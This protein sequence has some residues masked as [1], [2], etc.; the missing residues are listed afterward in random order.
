M[1]SSSMLLAA[2]L[3]TGCLLGAAGCDSSEPGP[4]DAVLENRT[5]GL[6]MYWLVTEEIQPPLAIPSDIDLDN[7]PHD[8]V[9][10][11]DTA[12]L[13]PCN[14]PG[15]YEEKVLLFWDVVPAEDET[16]GTSFPAFGWS[17]G[18]QIS[19]FVDALREN[20]CRVVIDSL[21]SP[22]DSSGSSLQP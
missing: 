10:V 3:A 15:P 2:V 8:L 13:G 5:D 6:M 11:G 22:L 12:V 17:N 16:T 18:E 19:N 9:A 4:A 7:P 20:D 1:R 14:L 21:P